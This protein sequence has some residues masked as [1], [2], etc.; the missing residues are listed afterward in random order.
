LF[1]RNRTAEIVIS[2]PWYHIDRG[3]RSSSKTSFLS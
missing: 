1:F 2:S 3:T